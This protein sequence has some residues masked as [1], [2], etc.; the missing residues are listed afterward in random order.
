MD[1]FNFQQG[2]FSHYGIDWEGPLPSTTEEVVEV[3][4]TRCPLDSLQLQTLA[5][6]NLADVS[7]ADALEQYHHVDE[8]VLQLLHVDEQQ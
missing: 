3:P 7:I 2:N 6:M 8:N 5:G 4:E 1:V